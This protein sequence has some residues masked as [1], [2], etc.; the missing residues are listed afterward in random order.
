MTA[1]ILITLLLVTSLS[2]CATRWNPFNWFGGE[3]EERIEVVEEEIEVDPRN[4]VAEIV[5]LNADATQGGLIISAIGLPPRQGYWEADLVETSRADGNLTLEFRVFEPLDPYTRVS[6][7][8]S[9]E[10]LAGTTFSRQNLAG[11]TSIT[12]IAQQNRRTVRQR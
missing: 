9:R 11:I 2:A 5:S 1:R 3:R 10:V 7:Q 12:V 4:L 8:R 6:T